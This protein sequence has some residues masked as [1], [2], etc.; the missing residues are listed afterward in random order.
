MIE[1]LYKPFQKWAEKNAIWVISDLHLGED[2]DLRIG[3]PNRP[4]A[5]EIIKIVN[6]KVGKNGTLIVCGDAGKPE[7]CA[8]LK[9]YKILIKG[10]HDIGLTAYDE[11]FDETYEGVLMIS[12]K[13]MLSHEPIKFPYAYNI[14]GH[15]HNGPAYE[16]GSMNV[17]A[18][19]IGYT[20]I[21]FNQFVKSGKLKECDNI[22]RETIDKATERKRK[23]GPRR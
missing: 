1:G 19:V 5:E 12:P 23:C 2:E 18:D 16:Y 22:H 17:C 10:N 13:I 8:K 6:Q 20:P 21:N 4:G 14:H 3:Y 11:V 9:G 7:L 15:V